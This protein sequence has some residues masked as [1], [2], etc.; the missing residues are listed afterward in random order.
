MNINFEQIIDKALSYLT[1]KETLFIVVLI[2]IFQS[3]FIYQK[4]IKIKTH[5]KEINEIRYQKNA[6]EC[7]LTQIKD[8]NHGDIIEDSISYLEKLRDKGLDNIT[9]NLNEII[10]IGQMDEI[11]GN[12]SA[13]KEIEFWLESRF[14]SIRR[15]SLK[16]LGRIGTQESFEIL[17]KKGLKDPHP[18]NN[19]YSLYLLG[20]YLS[21]KKYY[22]NLFSDSI[23]EYMKESRYLVKQEAIWTLKKLN[24]FNNNYVDLP[25]DEVNKKCLAYIF[26]NGIEK[27]N[28]IYEELNNFSDLNLYEFGI[29]EYGILYGKHDLIIKF[30]CKDIS[31]LNQFVL[32][33][34]QDIKWVKSSKTLISINDHCISYWQKE[35]LNKDSDRSISYILFKTS[36][37]D[38]RGVVACLWDYFFETSGG[39]VEAT[40]TYGD[41]DVL[42]KIETDNYQTK[43][44]L[45]SRIIR[46]IPLIISVETFTI[47]NGIFDPVKNDKVGPLLHDFVDTKKID[48][49][50]KYKPLTNEEIKDFNGEEDKL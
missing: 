14:L 1:L 6:I 30:L 24:S 17:I 18:A 49:P 19:V 43:D 29:L 2:V 8:T 27:E 41:P 47:Q 28:I 11:V 34:L 46:E 39:V 37:S 5:E 42:A 4:S 16:I 20:K 33:D 3:I 50:R 25:V 38:T 21:E 23:Q 36:A 45:I 44:L 22:I 26:V 31:E 15:Y 48:L 13:H 9:E 40:G 32:R 12:S 7:E 10:R 35:Y